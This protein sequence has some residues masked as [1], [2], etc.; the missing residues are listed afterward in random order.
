MSDELKQLEKDHIM[1][2]YPR[3]N[4]VLE[5]G[6][7]CYVYDQAGKQY[8]DFFGGLA[9]CVVG[10]SNPAVTEAITNQA[11]RLISVS[12]LYYTEPQIRLAQKL[13]ELSG[14][15][16]V[17]FCHSGADANEAAIKLAK[18]VTGKKE[19]IAFKNAFHGR[20]TG[21]LALTWK[22]QY[23]QAFLPLSPK[24]KFADYNDINSVEA[25]ITDDT[26]AVFVEPIQGESG[27]IVPDETF[28][29]ALRELCTKH[30]ILMIVDEVQTGLGRTG[31]FFAYQHTG[32]KPDIVTMAKGLA[33]GLPIGACL[34]D[35]ELKLGEH[36][37]TL[38]G[39]NLST[40]TALATINY[41]EQHHLITNAETIG[42][43]L[44]DQLRALQ[45][46]E[47]LISGVRGKGLMIGVVLQADKA[48]ELVEQALLQGMLINAAAPNV[49]RLVPPLIVTKKQADDC[50]DILKKVMQA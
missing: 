48:G 50:V 13:S 16:K 26:A 8:L 2:T 27:V 23:K 38:G 9:V 44:M 47:P 20:T 10:H 24:V 34:S 39:N 37:T 45:K 6:D 14:L 17:F 36:G 28:L 42:N 32:I 35:Y 19:F 22:Q 3:F 15:Q 29:P 41:I 49:V 5:K 1:Q 40:A 4:L 12:N 25:L 11:K 31:R 7:G 18:K 43:Y 46:T 33:N 21:S 30:K